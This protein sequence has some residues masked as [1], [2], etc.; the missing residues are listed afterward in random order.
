MRRTLA[1]LAT[2]AAAPLCS[3]QTVVGS[4]NHT[5]SF[6]G[7]VAYDPIDDTIWVFDETVDTISQY[8]RT[9]TLIVSLV[10]PIATGTTNAQPIGGFVDPVTGNLWVGDEGEVVYEMDRAGTILS[11]FSTLPSVNDVSALTWDPCTGNLWVANDSVHILQE[12]TRTGAPGVTINIAPAGSVDSDGAAY[13]P[14]SRTFFLGEDT[15][16]RILEVD[17]AGTL[18]NSWSTAGLGISP[19]GLAFDTR[20]GSI[21]IADTLTAPDRVVEVSGIIPAPAASAITNYGT[22]C[23][24]G[25]GSVPVLRASDPVRVGSAFQIAVQ[26]SLP[27]GGGGTRTLINIDFARQNVPLGFLG[28]PSCTAYAFPSAAAFVG[29]VNQHSRAGFNLCV[30]AVVP[31][32]VTL[33]FWAGNAPDLGVP[34]AVSASNGVEIVLQM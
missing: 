24:D 34:G 31:A 3:A 16:D 18:L 32:G 13:N 15:G 2:L 25:G 11:Q 6:A 23:P 27:P 19:E 10:A 9:G 8:D 26:T 12:F 20:T 14:V 29:T 22:G 33:T 30:P 21:F 5:G 7:G 17:A 4:F 28:A 1:V